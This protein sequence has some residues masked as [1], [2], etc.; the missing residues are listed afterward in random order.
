MVVMTFPIIINSSS[1]WS[2]T[3]NYN[4]LKTQLG[5]ILGGI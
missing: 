3:S 1:N 5:I 2:I 4:S